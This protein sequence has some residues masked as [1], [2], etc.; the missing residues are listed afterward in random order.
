MKKNLTFRKRNK[1]TKKRIPKAIRRKTVN[2]HRNL[3]GGV[4][5]SRKGITSQNDEEGGVEEDVGEEKRSR[6]VDLITSQNDEEGGVDEGKEKMMQQC[7]LQFKNVSEFY[8]A[9]DTLFTSIIDQGTCC[10]CSGFNATEEMAKC[11][12][13]KTPTCLACT[14]KFNESSQRG[15]I[16][17]LTC[18][19]CRSNMSDK[20][21]EDIREIRR[22]MRKLHRTHE[23]YLHNATVH[24][25]RAEEHR[26]KI[27]ALDHLITYTTHE[28][29]RLG[30]NPM[31]INNIIRAHRKMIEERETY[32]KDAK[33]AEKYHA[34]AAKKIDLDIAMLIADP[35]PHGMSQKITEDYITEKHA[36][37]KRL[38]QILLNRIKRR[39]TEIQEGTGNEEAYL[40]TYRVMLGIINSTFD[41]FLGEVDMWFKDQCDVPLP[42]ISSPTKVARGQTFMPSFGDRAAAR[43]TSAAVARRDYEDSSSEDS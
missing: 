23:L 16:G 18:A 29:T 11:S 5:R 31:D 22:K 43:P 7:Q 2:K 19:G 15:D 1:K 20:T 17:R 12:T 24:A 37:L 42:A 38:I 6:N 26:G 10:V 28:L 14:H 39:M 8:K 36:Q 33:R 27:D 30:Q 9:V 40:N 25:Q 41:S 34:S 21:A 32:A 13:C 3:R 4:K 35:Q